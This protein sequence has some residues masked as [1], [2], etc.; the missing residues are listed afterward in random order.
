M[1]E[2]LELYKYAIYITRPKIKKKKTSHRCFLPSIK[3][4]YSVNL[5]TTHFFLFPFLLL[6]EGLARDNLL[7]IRRDEMDYTC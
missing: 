3:Q 6:N 4:D 7:V 2:N 5:K 1:S